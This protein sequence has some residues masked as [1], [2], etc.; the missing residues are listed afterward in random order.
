MTSGWRSTP[1]SFWALFVSVDHVARPS[2]Y[3]RTGH[4]DT[5]VELHIVAVETVVSEI[6]GGCTSINHWLGMG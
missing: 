2:H 3:T 5:H 6:L 4:G 1:Q